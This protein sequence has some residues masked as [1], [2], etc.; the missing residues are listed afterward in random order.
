[1]LKKL[2]QIPT[3]E[4]IQAVYQ[5]IQTYIHRTPVLSSSS[6]NEIAGCEL[7]FKCENFQKI[8]AFKMRGA[9]SAALALSKEELK[10]GLATHSSGNHAQAVAK[11]ASILGVPAYIVMPENAPEVKKA[12]TAGYGA[13]IIECAPTTAARESKL[14]EVVAETGAYFIH[15]YNDYHVI[16]GQ[17]TAA[18]ELMEEVEGLD[19]IATPIGGGG[20]ISGT[21]LACHY[22]HPEIKVLGAEP[23]AVD[24]AY[25]SVK[26][27]EIIENKSTDTIADGLRTTIRQKTFEIIRDYVDEIITVDED[28]IIEA[29]KLIWQRMKIIIEPSCAVPLAAV[30]QQKERFQGQRIGIIITGGNVGLDNLPF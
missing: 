2:S 30:L 28:E 14:E 16:A 27:G 21:A 22:F 18:I 6:I 20:L 13:K 7:F 12:A 1:M 23:K 17:A 3:A 10:N 15:P 5:S 8:G 4:E 29:M 26:A 11:T 25:R 19:Q 9:I 24:D